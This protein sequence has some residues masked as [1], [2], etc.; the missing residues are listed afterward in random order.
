MFFN[1]EIYSSDF[2]TPLPNVVDE[3]ILAAPIDYRRRLYSNI[4][5]SGGSTM[6]K[7]FHRRLKKDIKNLVQ[8]RLEANHIRMGLDPKAAPDLKVEVV[9]HDMQRYAVW[10]GGSFLSSMPEFHTFCHTKAQYEEEGP[11]IA[12]HNAV[13]Q[14]TM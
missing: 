9:N 10:F 1:P 8:E 4:V 12:R 7:N 2:T 3:S 14:A 6:F 13:F 5:L 11:R